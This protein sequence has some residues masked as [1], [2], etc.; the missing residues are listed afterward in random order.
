MRTYAILL[1]VLLVC[2]STLAQEALEPVQPETRG[3]GRQTYMRRYPPREVTSGPLAAA[4]RAFDEEVKNVP[5]L[6]EKIRALMDLQQ[7]RQAI[8]REKQR[9]ALSGV[10]LSEQIPA[11]HELARRE[12]ALTTRQTELINSFAR[13]ADRILQQIRQRRTELNTELQQLRLDRGTDESVGPREREI[14]R[15]TRMYGVL[16]ERLGDVSP[17]AEPT[18]WMRQFARAFW[19]GDEMDEQFVEQA[20]RRLNELE[21][22]KEDMRRRLDQLDERVEEL[23]ELLESVGRREPPVRRPGAGPPPRRGERE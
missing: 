12:D 22:D 4:R 11:F 19:A 1:A 7:E 17:D 3:S 9:V 21:Q 14:A 8:W 10:P 2:S 15:S 13:D 5:L 20:R 18:E 6:D 23:R 16:I